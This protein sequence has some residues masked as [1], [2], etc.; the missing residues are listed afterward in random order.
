MRARVKRA[1]EAV[2]LRGGPARLARALLRGRTLVL[3]YHNV[4]PDGEAPRGDPSLH[5]P[6]RS[7]AEQLDL[8]CAT[9]EV[10]PLDRVLD[11]PKAGDHRPRVAITFDDAYRGAVTVGVEE[12]ARRGLPATVFVAPAFVGGRSFWWDAVAGPAGCLPESGRAHALASLRGEDPAV[13]AW[14]REQGWRERSIGP[15]GLAAAEEELAAA[16]RT[17]GITLGS[18]SWGHPNLARLEPEAL[19]EEL[20]RPLAWLRERYDAVL[21]WLA[22]PYGISSPAVEQAAG[23]VGYRAAVRV[24]GGW[25]SAPPANPYAIPRMNV[26]AGLSADGFALRAA[27][28]LGR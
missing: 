1:A 21:P 18:H 3:A 20:R 26:P 12:L 27:G 8:L 9:H 2:L 25:F 28:L 16:A 14:A 6:R 17:A 22:Y 23:E 7:F 15:A 11:P 24:E 4:V 13:R 5:L 10:V 19:R